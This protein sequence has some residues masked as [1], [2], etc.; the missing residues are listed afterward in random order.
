M[1]TKWRNRFSRGWR[2]RSSLT[3]H[4]SQTTANKVNKR[5]NIRVPEKSASR[6][7]KNRPRPITTNTTEDA[8]V[9]EQN[10]IAIAITEERK[11]AK[12][13]RD[14]ETKARKDAPM[15]W[16]AAV[17]PSSDAFRAKYREFGA[18]LR[19]PIKT[20]DGI[21]NACFTAHEKA[22]LIPADNRRNPALHR[23][24]SDNRA[25]YQA[26]LKSERFKKWAPR[27]GLAFKFT[28][29]YYGLP[30]APMTIGFEHSFLDWESGSDDDDDDE[31]PNQD[32]RPPGGYLRFLNS[33]GVRHFGQ[34]SLRGRSTNSRPLKGSRLGKGLTRTN[35]ARQHL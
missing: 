20:T 14:R 11:A 19:D 24:Q 17:D 22:M 32:G 29:V 34:C 6:A 8:L 21:I 33:Y 3:R 31:D 5:K 26:L 27:A 15:R 2:E 35:S 1:I 28:L 18:A 13:A 12:A 30:V 23:I 10:A 25:R 9:E 4:G 16:D 7:R